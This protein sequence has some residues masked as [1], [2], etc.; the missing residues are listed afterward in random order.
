[1]K[2]KDIFEDPDMVGQSEY[3]A[4]HDAIAGAVLVTENPE[5]E[6]RLTPQEWNQV[7]G[8]LIEFR[9]RADDLLQRI[10][11]GREKL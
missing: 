6:R 10:S 7:K 11:A 8:M 3:L 2:W 1:M 9:T 5:P 4:I